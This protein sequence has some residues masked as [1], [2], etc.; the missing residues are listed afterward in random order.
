MVPG[1]RVHN[2]KKL[3]DSAVEACKKYTFEM[4]FV[5][6]YGSLP[7]SLSYEPRVRI[8]CDFGSPNRALQL[9]AINSLGEFICNTVD[10]GVFTPGCLDSALDQFKEELTEKDVLNLRYREAD[11]GDPLP[12]P[13]EYWRMLYHPELRLPDIKIDYSLSMHFIMMKKRYMFLGGIDCQMFEYHSYA[14][15]D[16]MI[17]LQV[18]GG[19]IHHSNME[20]QICTHLTNRAGDHGPVHDAQTQNDQP[21]F[22]HLYSGMF[23]VNKRIR[24]GINNWVYSSPIWTRRFTIPNRKE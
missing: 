11:E 13:M 22:Q 21:R 18:D 8:I 9:A 10:D 17:R 16:L 19:K 1:I 7:E 20:G 14:L 23:D 4:L 2:W 24:L 6:P 3:F 12:M 15:H 5:S